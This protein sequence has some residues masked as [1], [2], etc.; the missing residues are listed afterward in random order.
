MAELYAKLVQEGKLD[1]KKVPKSIRKAV[2][3]ILKSE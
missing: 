3:A 1:V 2:T